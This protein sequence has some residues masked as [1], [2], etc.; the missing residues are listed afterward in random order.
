[1]SCK[2]QNEV[3]VRTGSCCCGN[4]SDECK[5]SIAGGA[6][7]GTGIGA[8]IGGPPGALLGA[9]IGGVAGS[10]LGCDDDCSCNR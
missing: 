10:M 9:L 8:C 7:W 5:D 4:Q 1:M 6:I 3:C 2:C